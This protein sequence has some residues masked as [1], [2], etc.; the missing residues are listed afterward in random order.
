MLLQGAEGGYLFLGSRRSVLE[1][2]GK[3]EVASASKMN[4]FG[5]S[6]GAGIGMSLLDRYCPELIVKHFAARLRGLELFCHRI[7]KVHDF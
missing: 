1:K 7:V 6:K 4:P 3:A 5:V 2:I